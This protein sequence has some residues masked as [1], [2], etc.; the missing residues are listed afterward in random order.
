M[1]G[2]STSPLAAD[3]SAKLLRTDTRLPGLITPIGWTYVVLGSAMC[4]AAG[5]QATVG[6]VH[7]TPSSTVGPALLVLAGV[8]A[9]LRWKPAR[10][11]A[12]LMSGVLLL[13]VPIGTVLGALMIYHLTI[14]RDQF[15]H[16]SSAN[17]R[18]R[19]P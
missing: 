16:P 14:Y 12:Y 11:L 15:A 13:A 3:L 4:V 18:W 1:P 10:W 9:I 2:P 8:G 19:G 7:L 5:F 6:P 17:H